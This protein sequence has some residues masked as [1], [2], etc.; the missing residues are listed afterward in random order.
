M[1]AIYMYGQGYFMGPTRGDRLPVIL[2]VHASTP[3]SI[4]IEPGGLG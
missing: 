4:N 2:E 1:C 3:P